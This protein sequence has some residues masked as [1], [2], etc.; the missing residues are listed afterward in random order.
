MADPKK[1][2]LDRQTAYLTFLPHMDEGFHTGYQTTPGV[3][4]DR[5]RRPREWLE[6][7]A[8][9][10]QT[11]GTDVGYS[12]PDVLAGEQQLRRLARLRPE[13]MMRHQQ[14][15]SHR[16]V[17][18]LL[19]LWDT[20]KT[21]ENWPKLELKCLSEG[22][23]SF[24]SSVSAALSPARAPEGVWVFTLRSAY[25]AQGDERPIALL[26]CSMAV[27]PAADSGDLSTLLP[28][29][30][31]WYDRYEKRFRDPCGSISAPDL[32]KLVARIR[33][34][35]R[36]REESAWQSPLLQGDEQLGSL[37]ERFASDLLAAQQRVPD[38]SVLYLRVLAAHTFAQTGALPVQQRTISAADFPPQMNPL[39]M[40]LAPHELPPSSADSLTFYELDGVPFA[41]QSTPWL[42][43]AAGLRTEMDILAK[44][45]KELDILKRYDARWRRAAAQMLRVLHADVMERTGLNPRVPVLLTRWAEELEQIPAQASRELTLHY[46]MD[47]CPAALQSLLGEMLGM[48][49]EG[50]IT[51]IFSDILLLCDDT[52]VAPL[53]PRLCQWLMDCSDEDILY[54]PLLDSIQFEWQGDGIAASFRIL[55]RSREGDGS[56]VSAVTFRRSYVL[57]H[58]A[59][60]GAAFA[61]ADYPSVT[62]WPNVRF[63]PD[64][65]KQYFVYAHQPGNISIYASDVNGWM[66]GER[67][68][69]GQNSWQTV[70]VSRF[71]AYVAMK[72]GDLTAGALV[73]DLPR[74][75]L[76]HEPAAAVAIDFGSI[77]T[78]V[79]LRQGDR[80]QPASLPECLHGTLLEGSRPSALAECFLPEDVLLPGSSSEATFFS[81]MDMFSDEYERWEGVLR[82]G[83]IYYRTSLEALTKKSAGALYYDLKWGEEAYAQRV[84]RLFLKQAM[85]QGALSARLWGSSSISWR[86]SMPNAMPLHK[87]EAYLEL[88]RG[89]ARELAAETGLPLT[90]GV[91]P[92]L[93]ATENQADGLYFLSRSEINAKSGYLNLDIG[94][95]TADL[96]L[97]LGG[98]R[99]AAIECSLLMGCR[100]MLFDSLME[101]HLTDFESDFGSCAITDA[102]CELGRV[103]REESSTLRGRR[104]CMLLLDDLLASRAEELREAMAQTRAIGRISYLESLLLLHVGFLFYLAGEL[105]ERARGNDA[106][107]SL[108]PEKME[109]C[110]A[111]N[112]GQLLKAFDEEQ[113]TR[114]CSMTL[115]RLDPAHPLKVLLPIQSSHPKQEVAR[116]LLFSDDQLLSTLSGAS[117][118]NGST[119]EPGGNLVL[120][121]LPLFYHVFPQAAQRLMPLAFEDNGTPALRGT[122][123]IEMETI[124]V[125]SASVST[126]DDAAM[127]VACLESLK[128]LWRI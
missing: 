11:Q 5:N 47:D 62:V 32:F 52:P 30:V 108:L 127:Y 112:G 15:I 78:T 125:N 82:D 39:F 88:M 128:R 33:M 61:P 22:S 4:S 93:Y 35:Q 119:G 43:C 76:K 9:N 50:L 74:R 29:C 13:E 114:L 26:S 123:A 85:L 89:L 56:A 124:F 14:I 53:S 46:P 107:V 71:P 16:A 18:A 1:E 68:H 87:Q 23:T 92:V 75:L 79:M 7:L 106:F 60:A 19:L 103:W 66:Q 72:C 104:K 17:L 109:L 28:A 80:V 12:I 65:W 34:L 20:W 102:I 86:I 10:M 40:A 51:G 25:E 45:Q 27:V 105:L 59:A 94:G 99:T 38:D 24:S 117:R 2:A 36:L 97:W 120:S 69:A 58:V 21:D 115:A 48:T 122:A 95:S 31:T 121:F 101:R 111:G 67:R 83:H 110:I 49:D 81:L 100:Q 54:A 73:N 37:L 91:P 41:C 64:A 42:L 118:W 8:R 6:S 126:G 98:G 84:A 44:L 116:G 77:S 90:P 3:V 96:S 57:S 63:A 113:Y 70:C 55:R